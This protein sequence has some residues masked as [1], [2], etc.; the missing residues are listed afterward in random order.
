MSNLEQKSSS[1]SVPFLDLNSIGKIYSGLSGK[2]S[3]DFSDDANSLFVTYKEV[4]LSPANNGSG[5][6]R[7]DITEE[8]KQNTIAKGDILF[9]GSSET[10]D[11]CAMSTVV[12]N[13]P[14]ENVYLNSFCFGFRLKN[15]E[16]FDLTYLKHY[17]RSKDFRRKVN[18]CAFGTTRYN[19][20]KKKFLKIKIP[21]PP[22]E[23][24]KK[25][26]QDLDLFTKLIENINIELKLRE[27]QY[28]HYREEILSFNELITEEDAES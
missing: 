25:I 10:P 13:D 22:L 7:V 3:S 28:L 8:E 14:E 16:E 9:T 26:G 5:L 20:S 11:E 15:K 21:V 2:N 1:E 4:F 24:Q 6:G 23:I 12:M 18:K 27:D 19:I 17:F